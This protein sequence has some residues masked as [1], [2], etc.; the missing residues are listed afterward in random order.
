MDIGNSDQSNNDVNSDN[1]FNLPQAEST[2]ITQTQNNSKNSS[3]NSTLPPM[4][5][6]SVQDLTEEYFGPKV[7]AKLAASN[8]KYYESADIVD[9]V[10]NFGKNHNPNLVNKK[11][12]DLFKSCSK[13]HFT[14]K[15]I[16]N[17]VYLHDLSKYGT[18]LNWSLI[19]KDNYR[20]LDHNDKISLIVNNFPSFAF[21]FV[22]LER[23]H[24]LSTDFE[25]T[26]TLEKKIKNFKIQG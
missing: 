6:Q 16:G 11:E 12:N 21:T 25:S 4:E 14:I 17:D 26:M 22:R 10:F 1:S 9:E 13:E 5:V 19:G 24:Q 18:F 8:P 7:W 20:K 15:K 3:N 23:E 2:K